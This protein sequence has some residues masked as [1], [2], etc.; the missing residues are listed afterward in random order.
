MRVKARSFAFHKLDLVYM[1]TYT[2][3]MASEH[4][5]KSDSS[6]V[7]L[8]DLF[9]FI[10]STNSETEKKDEP[11]QLARLMHHTLSWH[12]MERKCKMSRTDRRK[13]DFDRS[14]SHLQT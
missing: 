13:L 2:G 11:H 12:D 5:T 8:N 14:K 4:G 6:S 7:D 1:K 9:Q 10:C 3:R